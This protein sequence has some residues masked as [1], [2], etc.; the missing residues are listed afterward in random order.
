MCDLR[1]LPIYSTVSSWLL[2]KQISFYLAA[3]SRRQAILSLT[4][5]SLKTHQTGI[6]HR[7]KKDIPW[8]EV[9]DESTP[10]AQ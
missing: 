7:W 3:M 5:P 6:D 4:G 2:V 9:T 8:M 1:P 10:Y